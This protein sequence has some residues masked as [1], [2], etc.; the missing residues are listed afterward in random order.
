MVHRYYV[1]WIDLGLSAVRLFL[2]FTVSDALARFALCAALF[3]AS[4]IDLDWRIIPDVISLPGVA[5]GL[6]AGAFAM[7]DIG[8]KDS[9]FGMALGGGLFFAIGELYPWLGAKDGVGMRDPKPHATNGP[10]LPLSR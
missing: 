2:G 10:F 4:L 5:V 3:A 1:R 8:W 9:L 6:A 7:P